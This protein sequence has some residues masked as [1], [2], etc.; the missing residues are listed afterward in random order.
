MFNDYRIHSLE[1]L[2]N[3]IITL[4]SRI[5]VLERRLEYSQF[6]ANNFERERDQAW[7]EMRDLRRELEALRSQQTLRM[8]SPKKPT[9][10]ED[11]MKPTNEFA[12]TMNSVVDGFDVKSEYYR[13]TRQQMDEIVPVLPEPISPRK[14]SH[15]RNVLNVDF[16]RATVNRLKEQLKQRMFS[17]DVQVVRNQGGL[18]CI[19][20][21]R[22]SQ[23]GDLFGV[24]R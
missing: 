8:P 5:T 1:E 17:D 24:I 2:E 18:F 21:L 13:P 16:D 9:A 20:E 23:A 14:F 10:T 19:I 15:P 11:E 22:R 6:V 12:T 4:K 3:S 7:Q